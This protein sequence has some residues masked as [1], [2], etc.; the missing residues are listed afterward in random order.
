M[1]QSASHRILIR[2]R[3]FYWTSFDP[4]EPVGTFDGHTFVRSFSREKLLAKWR[5]R[6]RPREQEWQPIDLDVPR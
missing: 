2:K 3:L 4:M 1:S 6:L 5:W